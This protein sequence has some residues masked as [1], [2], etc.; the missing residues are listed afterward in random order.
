MS[1]VSVEH[2]RRAVFS[3]LN[4]ALDDRALLLESYDYW[5][6]HFSSD[7][8]F[9]VSSFLDG[10]GKGLG[11]KDEQRRSISIALYSALGLS[12]EELPPVPEKVVK[13]QQPTSEGAPEPAASAEVDL[14]DSGPILPA[15]YV[16]L[17]R[18]V[19]NMTTSFI[20]KTNTPAGEFREEITEVCKTSKLDKSEKSALVQWYS[21][22]KPTAAAAPTAI[23]T[24]SFRV[25]INVLYMAMCELGGPRIADEVMGNAVKDAEKLEAAQ[26][27][28][29]SNLL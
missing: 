2:N 6:E 3:A 20:R 22:D 16:I 8:A 12:E 27:F 10:L 13:R 11:L 23:A 17:G 7:I 24:E 25:V 18:V 28:P 21:N 26:H 4:R 9:R 1:G 15:P 19:E 5:E 29:P 14:G